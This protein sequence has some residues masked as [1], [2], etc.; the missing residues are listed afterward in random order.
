MKVVN[1]KKINRK[2][3]VRW[4]ERGAPVRFPVGW[5]FR[6]RLLVRVRGLPHLAK[7]ERDV[8]HPG[9]LGQAVV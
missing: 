2:S 6:V 3:G 5:L 4:C 9:F 1:A 7:N 8:G